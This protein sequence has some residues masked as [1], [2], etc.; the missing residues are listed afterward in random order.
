MTNTINPRWVAYKSL[1]I[2]QSTNADYMVFISMM[3]GLY[4]SSLGETITS[5]IHGHIS[6]HERFTKFIQKY[7]EE[8]Q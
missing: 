3:K 1:D 4:L 7:V 8:Q 5:A 6:D 2:P